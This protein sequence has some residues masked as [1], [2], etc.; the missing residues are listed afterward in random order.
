MLKIILNILRVEIRNI[1]SSIGRLGKSSG[2]GNVSAPVLV[3][4]GTAWQEADGQLKATGPR[5][6]QPMTP[7]VSCLKAD[8]PPP[9]HLAFWR[10]P[11]AR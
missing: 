3:L 11:L 7:C 4:P 6:T 1:P 10:C 9:H 2:G 5:P 8:V